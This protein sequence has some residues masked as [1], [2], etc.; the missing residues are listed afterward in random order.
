MRTYKEDRFELTWGCCKSGH[1]CS[2]SNLGLLASLR[3]FLSLL[4]PKSL[5]QRFLS[6]WVA[7]RELNLSYHIMEI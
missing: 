7:V 4:G 6:D 5:A 3:S 2:N 1:S